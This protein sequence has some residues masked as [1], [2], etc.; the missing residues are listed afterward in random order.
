MTD[1]TIFGSCASRNIF[2]IKKGVN[3]SIVK[4]I[5][6][7]NLL[8]AFQENS[9]PE[10]TDESLPP[11]ISKLGKPDRI[12]F[13]HNFNLR[14]LK[15]LLNNNSTDALLEPKGE[16]IL[17]DTWFL[18]SSLLY[19]IHNNTTNSTRL[20]QS[21]FARVASKYYTLNNY[22][23][24]EH[25]ANVNITYYV[26]QLCNFLRDNWGN[27]I[28]VF[29]SQPALS[30]VSG[31]TNADY[32]RYLE[33]CTICDYFCYQIRKKIDCFYIETP[34]FPLTIDANAVHYSNHVNKYLKKCIDAIIVNEPLNQ[35]ESQQTT[36]ILN[37]TFFKSLYNCSSYPQKH[38]DSTQ[39]NE[40]SINDKQP[41]VNVEKILSFIKRGID[42]EVDGA[43]E[44]LFEIVTNNELYQ[45]YSYLFEI[46]HMAAGMGKIQSMINLSYLYSSGIGT[47]LD[48]NLAAHWIR[49]AIQ[50]DKSVPRCILFDILSQINSPEALEEL[51][52]LG[53]AGIKDS[54]WEIITRLQE[55]STKK[56]ILDIFPDLPRIA[57]TKDNA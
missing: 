14:M 22:E 45:E 49:G 24:T 28:I 38:T 35:L 15:T 23:V 25:E 7:Q 44:L 11:F 55:I 39:T 3:Y 29:N 16:W 2:N 46:T 20:L 5:Q 40:Y 4:Y 1:L 10:V 13:S 30:S 51:K 12:T 21:G 52:E 50:K 32:N 41:E 8:L 9:F 47:E 37:Y 48:L 56:Y 33:K 19:R 57:N 6:R 42:A 36:L 34:K 17:I 53:N 26:D 31:G 18:Q 54:D 27:K 43:E